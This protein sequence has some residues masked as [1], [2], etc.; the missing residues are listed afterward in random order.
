[1]PPIGERARPL[2]HNTLAKIAEGIRRMEGEEYFIYSYYG[3]ACYSRLD[4]PLGTCTS[5]DRHALIKVAPSGKLEEC[6]YR[7]LTAEEI[8]KAM[9]FPASYI[10]ATGSRSEI[11]RQCGL[12]VTPAVAYE[13]M[14]SIL[15]SFGIERVNYAC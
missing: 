4:Q 8:K 5:R 13:L 1:M 12:A 6:G 9:G 2:S 15:R 10:F 14:T 11:I 7:L 3:N